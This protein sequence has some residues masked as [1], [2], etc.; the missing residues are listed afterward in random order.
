[1]G[2]RGPG[3]MRR[4]RRS[5]PRT[6][7]APARSRDSTIGLSLFPLLAQQPD[8]DETRGQPSIGAK[9]YNYALIWSI[10]ILVLFFCPRQPSSRALRFVAA[11]SPKS[12]IFTVLFAERT[13][14]GIAALQQQDSA[15]DL[16][17]SMRRSNACSA[18]AP[19]RTKTLSIFPLRLAL[20]G[21]RHR[22]L[23]HVFARLHLVER[24]VFPAH[25]RQFIRHFFRVA[26][27]RKREPY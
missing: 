12:T 10:T 8:V 27:D 17:V 6:E 14:G 11:I 26:H 23:D 25:R 9:Y 2:G 18:P 5:R 22:T 24:G 4:Q 7:Q 21:E 19:D 16:A 13:S 3:P 20:L 1:M 15:R